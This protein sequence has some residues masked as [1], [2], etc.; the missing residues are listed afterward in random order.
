MTA[1]LAGPLRIPGVDPNQPFPLPSELEATLF[2]PN[3]RHHGRRTLTYE[4]EDGRSIA[5]V[6]RRFLPDPANFVE[7]R[8]HAVSEGDRIDNLAF[9]YL[10]DSEQYWLLA[11][12]NA[13]MHPGE[14]TERIGR[15]LRV[16]LPEG[17]AGA[18]RA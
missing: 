18:T 17:V 13:A 1:K 14:L 16:T 11:D 4:A 10:G 6:D 15:R 5:Y 7:I 3:S 2:P 12:A 8:E 9:D